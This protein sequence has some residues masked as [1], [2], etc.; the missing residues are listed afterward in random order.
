MNSRKKMHNYEMHTRV[1]PPIQCSTELFEEEKI[2]TKFDK[3]FDEAY[4]KG[5]Y[6][7]MEELIWHY[8]FKML[9]EKNQPGFVVPVQK[10][11]LPKITT[12][13]YRKGEKRD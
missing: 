10:F 9:K 3:D 4:E 13:G 12:G 1:L 7:S 5:N 11:P 2:K 8:I 6:K